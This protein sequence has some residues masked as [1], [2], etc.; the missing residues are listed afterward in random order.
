VMCIINQIFLVPFI[1]LGDSNASHL[2]INI[3]CKHPKWQVTERA[4]Y[5][6]E[7]SQKAG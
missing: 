7:K 3:K 4:L 1:C 2:H 5:K 6:W